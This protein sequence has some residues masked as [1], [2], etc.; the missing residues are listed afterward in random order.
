MYRLGVRKNFIAQ[1]FLIGGD[2]GAE[3]SRHSHAYTIEV[4]CGA[5]ET[6]RHNYLIDIVDLEKAMNEV[7]GRF[8]D[9]LLNDLPEFNKTNPS[10]E[11]FAKVI[12]GA[13]QP[14]VTALKV[15]SFTVTLWENDSCWAAYVEDSV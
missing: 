6:D 5:R 1:H 9:R 11:L 4:I 7:I 15:E 3:N 10:L 8:S 2:W 12:H 13:L 14:A